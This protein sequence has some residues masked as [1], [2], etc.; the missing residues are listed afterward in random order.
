LFFVVVDISAPEYP[1]HYS[2]VENGDML[3]IVVFII[4]DILDTDHLPIV[5]HLSNR[6]RTRKV[7]GSRPDEI[8]ES[9]Q[10]T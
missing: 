8:N 1:T 2:P 10:C 6:I 5:F 7:T 4:S 9:F 3:D